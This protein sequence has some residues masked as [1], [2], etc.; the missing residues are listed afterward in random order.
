MASLTRFIPLPLL[1]DLIENSLERKIIEG[2]AK[3]H[4]VALS[5]SDLDILAFKTS[6]FSGVKVAVQS[7]TRLVGRLF[8]KTLVVF[9]LK[10]AS[11][12]FS[13]AYHIGYLLDF[14]CRTGWVK[15]CSPARLRVAIDQVCDQKGTSPVNRIFI[16][17]MKESMSKLGAVK[18]FIIGFFR[19]QPDRDQM[20]ENM[21]ED[22]PSEAR[23]LAHRLEEAL[24]LMPPQYFL[25][26][27]DRF[28]AILE[29]L[30]RNGQPTD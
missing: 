20:T 19:G 1:D 12:T 6:D 21:E 16:R 25:E 22:A 10:D 27:Q 9:E 5:D 4:G 14:A 17:I 8:L 11:D 29:K 26:L 28:I 30:N 24:N 15:T 7:A 3:A 18:D 13:A 2:I 23:E